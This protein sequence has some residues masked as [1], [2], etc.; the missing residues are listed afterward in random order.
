M[1]FTAY[2]DPKFATLR[3]VAITAENLKEV[4]QRL[5]I[6]HSRSNGSLPTIEEKRRD[7]DTLNTC[8]IKPN[9]MVIELMHV[10]C[11]QESVSWSDVADTALK[12]RRELF[13]F[14]ES[15][16]GL[17]ACLG[18]DKKTFFDGKKHAIA[19]PLVIER[20]G[21]VTDL[22]LCV[23]HDQT[24]PVRPHRIFRVD[25]D[26]YGNIARIMPVYWFSRPMV[27]ASF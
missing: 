23:V 24:G 4:L 17:A 9:A 11:V 5:G 7:I 18:S 1:K 22:A 20:S 27:T 26:S 6:D 14:C 15:L 8:F 19:L 3:N 21:V 2:P 25:M 16:F 10:K 12:L 13:P